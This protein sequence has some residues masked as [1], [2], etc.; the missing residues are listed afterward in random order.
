MP[1][2]AVGV[3]AARAAVAAA[4]EQEA[5]GSA[6]GVE[7]EDVPGVFGNDIRGEEVDFAGK[8]GDGASAG[9][10]MGVDAV[11]AV[12]EL[13]GAFHLHAVKR[14]S[15]IVR[16]RVGGAGEA[17]LREVLRLR[18]SLRFANRLAALRMTLLEWIAFLD[19]EAGVDDEV[20]AFAVAVGTGDAETEVRG[21]EDESEFGEFSAALGG[22]FA[23]A[24]SLRDGL[25][26]DRLISDRLFLDKLGARR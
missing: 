14:G 4:A 8:V 23:L 6:K 22:E 10:A 13:G 1:G 18:K 26:G 16:V 7:R 5:G 21:F 24:G 19:Y 15:R 20:V 17:G 11:E 9:A 3:V 12:Q 25:F 2:F